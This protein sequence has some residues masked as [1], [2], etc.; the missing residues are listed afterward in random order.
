MFARLLQFLYHG[1]YCY[2]YTDAFLMYPSTPGR[3]YMTSIQD[4]LVSQMNR[5]A[6]D[7]INQIKLDDNLLSYSEIDLG[8]YDL[9]DKYNIPSL[10]EY[11]LRCCTSNF[12]GVMF[13]SSVFSEH[14]PD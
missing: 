4:L 11:S 6:C 1:G 3:V 12:P 13:M 5:P 10:V 7:K 8:V 2:I 9:A 14:Y